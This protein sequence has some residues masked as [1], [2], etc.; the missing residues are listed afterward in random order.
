LQAN[1][2]FHGDKSI[3]LR[4]KIMGQKEIKRHLELIKMCEL[5][6]TFKLNIVIV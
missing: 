4:K 6:M 5:T 3:K 2:L 1:P